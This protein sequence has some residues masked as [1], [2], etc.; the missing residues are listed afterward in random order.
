MTGQLFVI[1]ATDGPGT[2]AL[3]AQHRDGHLAHFRAN[4]DRIAVAGPMGG[5]RSGSLV[6][7]MAASE[8]EAREFI[9]GD[10]FHA[11]GIWTD[12]DIRPFKAST[13]RWAA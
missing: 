13:G 10:P 11:A 1:I 9:T 4:A 6:V 5:E 12:I 2:D 3:R 7:L 8:A